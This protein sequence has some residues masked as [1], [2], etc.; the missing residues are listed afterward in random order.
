[1][2]AGLLIVDKSR[3]PTSHD[4]VAMVRRALRT[5]EVGHA[6]TLDPMAT[7]VLV[8]VVGE[9]TKLTPYLT[10][11]SKTYEA[12]VRFGVETDSLDAMGKVTREGPVSPELAAMLVSSCEGRLHDALE[13]AIA[14]ERERTMQEP[15]LVSAI[16]VDGERAYDLARRGETMTLPSREVS[17]ESVELIAATAEPATATFRVNV[18]K[19]YFVRAFARDL[20][21]SLDTVGHLTSL[22]RTRS[23]PF[24]CDSR[25]VS[26]EDGYDTMV[27]RF[28]PLAAAA[29]LALPKVELTLAGE[30]EARAGRRVP[31]SEMS[32]PS[33]APAQAWIGPDGSLVAVGT[34]DESGRGKVLR[35]FTLRETV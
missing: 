22:R 17:V 20:A 31:E 19:G 14:I 18:S 4:V 10:G 7:G 30:R 5:R 16:H 13:N 11:H 26:A 23:G 25:A 6:G 3:G 8:L 35:G 2:T 33:D 12:T 34:R 9:A 29:A 24:A 1:M 28:I 27:E 15:P 32:P 21:L